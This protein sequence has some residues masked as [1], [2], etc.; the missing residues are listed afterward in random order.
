M[1]NLDPYSLEAQK[2]ARH[3]AIADA[4]IKQSQ[5]PLGNTQMVSGVAVPFSPLQGLAKLGEAYAGTKVNQQQDQATQALAD[6]RKSDIAKAISDYQRATTPRPGM[7]AT[8]TNPTGGPAFNPTPQDRQSA[9]LTLM[10]QVGDPADAAKMMVAQ[11]MTPEKYTTVSPGSSIYR[12]GS[13][14]PEKVATA[15]DKPATAPSSVQAYE[16]AKGQGY[17]GTFEQWQLAQ[18]KAGASRIDVN[19]AGETAYA[20]ALGSKTAENDIAQYKAAEKAPD[21]VAKLDNLIKQL[22]TSDAITGPGANVILNIKRAQ[23]FFMGEKNAGRQVSDTQLLDAMLGSDVFPMIQE[24]GIGARGMDTPA[25]RDFLRK[26]F[27]GTIDVNKDTLIKMT[28]IRRAVAA[29]A[30]EKWNKRV[31]SGELDRY[32]KQ[33]GAPKQEIQI[34]EMPAVQSVPSIDD[35]VNKYTQ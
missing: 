6:K 10:G 22:R 26:V 18:R 5:E 17:T 31:R 24:L 1:A 8:D 20:K 16:Y 30:A 35:L 11:A 12:T 32:F 4:L 34:P 23:Q 15:P 2:I 3:R 29:R 33:I 9:A 28:E 7:E 25:E 19:T 13:S 14:G 27:T 21:N